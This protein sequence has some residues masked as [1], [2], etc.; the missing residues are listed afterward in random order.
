MEWGINEEIKDHESISYYNN[1]KY[2]EGG[3]P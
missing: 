2:T 1:A 3:R